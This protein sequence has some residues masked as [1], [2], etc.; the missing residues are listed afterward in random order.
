VVGL[1]RKAAR[2]AAWEVRRRLQ[3]SITLSTVQGRFKVPTSDRIISRGLYVHRQLE[4]DDS[5]AYVKLLRGLGL[6]P[7][8]PTLLD[9]GANIGMIGIGLL[10]AGLVERVVAIEP[11]PRN[12]DFLVQNVAL[13]G[14]GAKVTC[15]P[16][17][18]SD[19]RG[20]L[21][22]ELSEENIADHRVRSA[23]FLNEATMG[24]GSRQVITVPAVP[25]DEVPEAAAADLIWIDVQGYEAHAFRGARSILSQGIP[26]EAEIW[27][28]GL[29]RAGTAPEDFA[30]LVGEFWSHFRVVSG[31]IHDRR[32]VSEL[33]AY[34]DALGPYGAFGNAVFTRE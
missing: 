10:C 20:E 18:A 9:I 31:D 15:L 7:E 21:E 13:N 27:P 24:E 6:V 11:E 30:A 25:L 32:P 28:Y 17:A 22:F 26:V 29:L 12:F 33:R 5:V 4:F 2:L 16:L 8:R 3:A 23:G 19:R 34:M 14:L 1:A